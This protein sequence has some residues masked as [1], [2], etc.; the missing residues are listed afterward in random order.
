[1]EKG[2]QNKRKLKEQSGR[3]NPYSKNLRNKVQ[4]MVEIISKN[5]KQNKN[6]KKPQKLKQISQTE[7]VKSRGATDQRLMTKKVML[8]REIEIREGPRGRKE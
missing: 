6:F 4:K 7:V 2:S 1:M 8:A 5:I 3:N